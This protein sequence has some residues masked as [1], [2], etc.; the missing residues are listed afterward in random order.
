MATI[1]SQVHEHDVVELKTR[2][3]RWPAGTEGTVIHEQGAWKLVEIA[4]DQG[5]M[6]DELDV[7]ED[8]L[9]LIVKYS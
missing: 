8:Q 7:R 4:D 6:L 5:V 1:E 9:E 2:I 3:G